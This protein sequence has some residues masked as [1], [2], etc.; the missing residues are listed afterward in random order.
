MRIPV[1]KAHIGILEVF[2]SQTRVAIIEL[3]GTRSMNIGELAAALRLSSAIITRHIRQME[4][5]GL[6]RCEAQPGIRG[7]QKI[8]SLAVEVL[9]LQL[10]SQPRE[11]NIHV[12]EIPIG[13]YSG[14]QV[15][16]TC[17]LA[18]PTGLIGMNDDP[19]YFADPAHVQA[20]LLWFGSGWVE[21][22]VPNFLLG[23][24]SARS[25]EISLEVCSEAPVYKEHHPSDIGFRVNGVLLGV[26]TSPG[27][28]GEKMGLLTPDWWKGGSQYGI[29]KTIRVDATGSYIDGVQTSDNTIDRLAIQYGQEITFRVEVDEQASH[30]GGLNL[31][32][33]S[34][35]NYAQDIRVTLGYQG[36]G[37][38]PSQGAG[39]PLP[40]QTK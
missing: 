17:G 14:Y 9:T 4:T 25:L 8:C 13:Q 38:M 1:D 3:L 2:S 10:R 22:R 29:L 28:F 30:M 16:P 31:F 5:A 27:D 40:A 32:G 6:I 35:G 20:G 11:Q 24:Q 34:F 33:R 23:G 21:Y 19:R 26:W 15:R 18:S 7:T 39:I 12:H 36:A 37:I